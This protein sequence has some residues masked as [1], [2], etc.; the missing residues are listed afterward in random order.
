MGCALAWAWVCVTVPPPELGSVAV[1]FTVKALGEVPLTTLLSCAAAIVTPV[2][3]AV[4]FNNFTWTYCKLSEERTTT[5]WEFVIKPAAL[6]SIVNLRGLEELIEVF[7]LMARVMALLTNFALPG[8]SVNGS[9]SP[10]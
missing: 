7:G 9:P 1:T 10:V 8:V 5:S 3:K 4:G 2:G 6:A